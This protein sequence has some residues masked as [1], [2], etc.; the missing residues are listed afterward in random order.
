MLTI[1][2][3]LTILAENQHREGNKGIFRQTSFITKFQSFFEIYTN[4]TLILK[5]QFPHYL[6]NR[7]LLTYYSL[8]INEILPL[9]IILFFAG[10]KGP[11]MS[12]IY[13]NNQ[14]IL[15]PDLI[16]EFLKRSNSR[17]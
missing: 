17:R 9:K 12:R 7:L 10:G 4:F 11:E 3:K 2:K 15:P 8:E 13:V 16:I 1:N 6:K 5:N 14:E